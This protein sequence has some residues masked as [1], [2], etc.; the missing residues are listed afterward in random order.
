MRRS[1]IDTKG[2][3]PYEKSL[4]PERQVGARCTFAGTGR[5]GRFRVR[6]RGRR[7]V[8]RLSGHWSRSEGRTPGWGRSA[9]RAGPHSSNRRVAD[10]APIHQF[11][12]PPRRGG[13]KRSFAIKCFLPIPNNITYLK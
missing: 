13:W 10:G 2:R 1:E 7:R 3:S 8:R 5:G 11:S 12:A 9:L 6:L 4:C